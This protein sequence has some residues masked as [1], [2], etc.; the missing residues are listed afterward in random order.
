VHILS[1][2]KKKKLVHIVEKVLHIYPVI[3]AKLKNE[4]KAPLMKNLKLREE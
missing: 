1:L 3:S 2:K 4:L